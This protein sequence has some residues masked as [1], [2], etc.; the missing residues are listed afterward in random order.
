MARQAFMFGGWLGVYKSTKC[1][2]VYH[3]GKSDSGNSFIG[4]AAAGAAMSV[5]SGNPRLMVGAAIVNGSVMFV[6]DM[7]NYL[8]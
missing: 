2:A 5:A 6:L 8:H 7:L 1:M 3:R 4:G